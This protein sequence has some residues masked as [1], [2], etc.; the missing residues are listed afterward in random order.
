MIHKLC[1][2]RCWKSLFGLLF[3]LLS[4]SGF[5]IELQ[6]QHHHYSYSIQDTDEVEGESSEED[7]SVWSLDV[8]NEGF[9]VPFSYIARFLQSICLP[10]SNFAVKAP[11]TGRLRCILF[12]QLKYDSCS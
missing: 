12:H 5:A 4:L 11:I 6:D 10:H 3:L 9:E 8:L 1:T 7:K 2:Q